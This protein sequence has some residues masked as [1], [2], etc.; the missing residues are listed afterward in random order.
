MGY[1]FNWSA[2]FLNSSVSPLSVRD[3]IDHGTGAELASKIAWAIG[4]T[5][6]LPYKKGSVVRDDCKFLANFIMDNLQD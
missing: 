3:L 4:T 2:T 5:L 6:E 1:R